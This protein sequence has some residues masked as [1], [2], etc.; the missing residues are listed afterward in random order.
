MSEITLRQAEMIA[1][2]MSAE[3]RTG[4]SGRGM[5]GKECVGFVIDGWGDFIGGLVE[6]VRD[7]GDVDW[8]NEIDWSIV[9]SDSM[10]FSTIIYLPY[11]K[12]SDLPDDYDEDADDD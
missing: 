2:Y 7:Y 9:N 4:Y 6:L 5:Y 8:F 11:L 10:G 1:E 3:L 12:V